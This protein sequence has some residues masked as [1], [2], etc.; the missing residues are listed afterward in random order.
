[1]V[2]PIPGPPIISF[3]TAVKI[4]TAG[5]ITIIINVPRSLPLK[6]AVSKHRMIYP[7]HA[8]RELRQE[9]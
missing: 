2:D 7:A 5:D 6:Q 9:N 4:G 8:L 3:I 1:M